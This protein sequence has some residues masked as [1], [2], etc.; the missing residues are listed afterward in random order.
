MTISLSRTLHIDTQCL[1]VSIKERAAYPTII[2]PPVLSVV[3][4]QFLLIYCGIFTGEYQK[5]VTSKLRQ[6]LLT[7]VN[8]FMKE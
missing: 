2:R 3:E 1:P 5:I 6:N 7:K 8:V 4:S